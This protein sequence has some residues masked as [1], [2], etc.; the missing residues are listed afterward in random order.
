MS[1]CDTAPS[2]WR[3]PAQELQAESD[4]QE[5]HCWHDHGQTPSGV[6][7]NARLYHGVEEDTHHEDL[8]DLGNHGLVCCRITM[9]NVRPI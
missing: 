1:E 4:D 3:V 6:R 5:H 2:R 9:R 7:G 8:R